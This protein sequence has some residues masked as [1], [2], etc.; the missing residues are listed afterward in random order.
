MWTSGLHARI[1]CEIEDRGSMNPFPHGKLRFHAQTT[2]TECNRRYT[3]YADPA[4]H[5]LGG[6][7]RAA[8]GSGSPTSGS[9][10]PKSSRCAK[11]AEPRRCIGERRAKQRRKSGKRMGSR[12]YVAQG[13]AGAGRPS[14]IH[15]VRV[16]LWMKRAICAAGGCAWTTV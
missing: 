15:D 11:S 5:E 4:V 9:M 13:E 8:A 16:F 7:A 14:R 3:C 6:S 10:A 2:L 1:V 12:G